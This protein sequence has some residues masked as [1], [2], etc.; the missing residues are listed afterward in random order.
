MKKEEN[1]V[2]IIQELEKTQSILVNKI[3]ELTNK[4]QE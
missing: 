4:L 3:E 2:E 1:L